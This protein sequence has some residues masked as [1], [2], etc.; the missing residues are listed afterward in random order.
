MRCFNGSATCNRRADRRDS[1]MQRD[2]KESM[3]PDAVISCL[4]PSPFHLNVAISVAQPRA[5]AA[6][7]RLA[8]TRHLQAPA[9][10]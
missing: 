2:T 6:A 1:R 5:R 7:W 3:S 9:L 10:E 8:W 4:V